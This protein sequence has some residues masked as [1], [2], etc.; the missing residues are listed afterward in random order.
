MDF[1]ARC[2]EVLLDLEA[3]VVGVC[4]RASS[5]SNSDHKD[6]TPI[7]TAHGVPVLDARDINSQRSVQWI[8]EKSPDVIF[9]LGWSNLLKEEILGIAP[10]GVVGFHPAALPQNRG[11]HPLIWALALGLDATASTFFFMDHGADSGDILSQQEIGI[12]SDDDAASLYGK[13]KLVAAEQI[14]EFLPLLVSG[15]YLVERQDHECANYWRKRGMSDGAIDWRMSASAIY[16]LVR[17]LTVPYIGA[18]FQ[19]EGV[20]IK[21]WKCRVIENLQNNIEPGR[22][23]GFG[24]VGPIIKCGEGA[25]ELISFDKRFEACLGGFL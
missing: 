18:H 9:C 2:L 13:I 15:D 5:A 4:T 22:V 1:S 23:I 6:L 24:D 3:N 8:R 11:R 12:S 21:V 10:L 17:A 16:N 19:N 25:V 20:N 14:K 7:A